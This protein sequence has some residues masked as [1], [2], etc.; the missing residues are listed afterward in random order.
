MSILLIAVHLYPFL[1][2]FLF[3]VNTDRRLTIY[4]Y[5]CMLGQTN[6]VRVYS[7]FLSFFFSNKDLS[8]IPGRISSSARA[9]VIRPANNVRS[10]PVHCTL[11]LFFLFFSFFFL[12]NGACLG[13]AT[14]L[15]AG[16]AF[17][18]LVPGLFKYLTAA[19]NFVTSCVNGITFDGFSRLIF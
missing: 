15:F 14:A 10:I 19:R 2:V 13:M 3:K 5:I 4:V 12:W 16:A 6:V 7:F 18:C 9:C 8:R 1:R 17:H 11:L